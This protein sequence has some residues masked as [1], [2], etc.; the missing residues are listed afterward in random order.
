MD[1]IGASVWL[2][3]LC[4]CAGIVGGC[5]AGVLEHWLATARDPSKAA[6]WR[7]GPRELLGRVRR[8]LEARGSRRP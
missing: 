6:R 1:M 8:E 7:V 3:L 2:G 5:A 4:L